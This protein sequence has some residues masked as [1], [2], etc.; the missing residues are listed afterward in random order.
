MKRNLILGLLVLS[1]LA[2]SCS[3]A[4]DPV[5]LKDVDTGM[6]VTLY[7]PF[8][9]EDIGLFFYHND[10]FG[11]SVRV[12]EIFTQVVL[13]PENEDGM[14]LESEDGKHRFRASGGFV[15]FEDELQTSMESAKKY[16]EEN[17]DGAMIFEKTGDDWWELS[18]WNGPEKGV[19]KFMTNGESWSECEITWPGQPRNAPGE[20]DELFERSLESMS[21]PAG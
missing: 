9:E 2:A 15:L 11:Y 20:Y 16:V 17:V 10:R 21:F 1:V 3:L 18:W 19:R 12:P 4:A 5:T 6:T 8:L 13:L 14:I 7:P